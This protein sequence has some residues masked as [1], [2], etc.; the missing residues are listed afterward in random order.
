[1]LIIVYIRYHIFYITWD[2]CTYKNA[3]LYKG[4]FWLKLQKYFISVH[5]KITSV[6]LIM[7]YTRISFSSQ[8]ILTFIAFVFI[9]YNIIRTIIT[10]CTDLRDVE[11]KQ[12]VN[13]FFVVSTYFFVVKVWVFWKSHLVYVTKFKVC[14]YFQRSMF[15]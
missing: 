1:M 8:A 14:N 9:V 2:I 12:D 15:L 7:T 10:V 13:Y 5:G 3:S 4:I 11:I 6:I